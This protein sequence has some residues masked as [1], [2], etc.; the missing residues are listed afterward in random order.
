[1]ECTF[2]ELVLIGVMCID[3]VSTLYP[4]DIVPSLNPGYSGYGTNL[5]EP[6]LRLAYTPS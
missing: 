1:M 3:A 2:Q 5:G 6:R 4:Y